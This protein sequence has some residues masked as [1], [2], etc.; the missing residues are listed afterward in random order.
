MNVNELR[1]KIQKNQLEPVYLFKGPEIGEKN[2]IIELIEKKISARGEYEKIVLHCDEFL[3]PADLD[4]HLQSNS[5][6]SEEKL[7]LIKSVENISDSL[8]GV[9]ENYLMPRTVLKS[10][11]EPMI[12]SVSPEQKKI[13]LTFY[14]KDHKEVYVRKEKMSTADIRKLMTLL[15]KEKIRFYHE[16][17]F[18]ILLNETGERIPSKLEALLSDEQNIMFWE[19]FENQ[20]SQWIRQEFKKY[21]FFIEDDAVQFILDTVENNR[22]DLENTILNIISSYQN[23]LE[24]RVICK[25]DIESFLFHSKDESVFSLYDSMLEQKKEK[26]IHILNKLFYSS[27][28]EEAVITLL[29]GL[30]WS[31]R[32]F[33]RVLELYENQRKNLDEIYKMLNINMKKTR[34]ILTQAV[35]RY[36]FHHIALQFYKLSELDYYLKVLPDEL[37]LIRLQTFVIN[38]MDESDHISFLQGSPQW[39]L[40]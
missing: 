23:T 38:F 20:K 2:E 30:L 21:Q 17:A 34:E 5:L 10:E 1:Q 39:I 9:L 6:F 19:M 18:I 36:S 24:K 7:I 13:L 29:S 37:K 28:V 26:A 8:T 16:S 15:E 22:S 40:H 31:H 14:E 33:F 11:F 3:T 12:A 35:N 25:S 32:R 27:G 4:H